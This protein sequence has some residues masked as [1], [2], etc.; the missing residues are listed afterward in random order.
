[1]A[2]GIYGLLAEASNIVPVVIWLVIVI[3][4][5][6]GLWKTFEK[7]GHPG[8]A[9]IIPIYNIYILC[10]IAGRPG[11]WVILFFIPIVS[12]VIAI[13]VSLDVAKNF[14]KSALFGIGLALLG[15]I[16]YPIL[17]FGDAQYI[18]APQQQGFPVQTGYAPPPPR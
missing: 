7:A 5:I 16:F 14:G 13:I 9:A 18:G 2:E 11:W 1:M 3:A 10:K 12:I 8:W 17:G 4:A 6:A 15:F